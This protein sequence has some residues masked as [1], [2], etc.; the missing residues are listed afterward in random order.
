MALASQDVRAFHRA[1]FVW[2]EAMNRRQEWRPVL[3]AEVKRWSAKSYEELT[4]ELPE[5]QA[6][7]LVFE[8]KRYQVEVD[9]LE[10]NNEYLHVSVCV[11]DGSLPAS[12]TPL[13][14]SFICRRRNDPDRG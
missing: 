14:E 13:C 9:L 5:V 8:S 4:A 7:E 12:I 6:Y 11:D 3:E 10:Q 2:G 1:H